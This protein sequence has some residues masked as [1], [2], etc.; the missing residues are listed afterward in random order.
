MKI[1]RNID[2]DYHTIRICT[3]CTVPAV[4]AFDHTDLKTARL[5]PLV[6]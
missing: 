5:A 6:P 4:A 3:F 1:Y 2:S